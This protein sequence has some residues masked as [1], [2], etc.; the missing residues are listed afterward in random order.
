MLIWFCRRCGRQNLPLWVLERCLYSTCTSRHVRLSHYPCHEFYANWSQ[1]PRKCVSGQDPSSPRA[2]RSQWR[3]NASGFRLASQIIR[4]TIRRIC[5]TPRSSTSPARIF[6]AP[7][8]MVFHCYLFTVAD[9]SFFD[10][11][12]PS[13]PSILLP[14]SSALP[15]VGSNLQ[16]STRLSLSRQHLYAYPYDLCSFPTP[17]C[18]HWRDP[19]ACSSCPRA[20]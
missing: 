15:S 8:R 9:T 19:L 1:A 3:K 16:V 7:Q 2:L 18:Q 6:V 17:F 12:W 11:H 4:V 5:S 13:L 20:P 14:E 10:S